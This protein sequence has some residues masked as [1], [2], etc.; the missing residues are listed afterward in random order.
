MGK[1]RSLKPKDE[2]EDKNY[3]PSKRHIIELTFYLG[4]QYIKM[5]FLDSATNISSGP[6]VACIATA[7]EDTSLTS[8]SLFC[9][10]TERYKPRVGYYF[11]MFHETCW[12]FLCQLPWS[13][14]SPLFKRAIIHR[15]LICMYTHNCE[16]HDLMNTARHKLSTRLSFCF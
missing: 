6:K 14:S 4:I 2:Y 5:Y 15:F 12:D 13:G 1:Q 11:C 9:P 3:E 10:L 7:S 16:V 8:V